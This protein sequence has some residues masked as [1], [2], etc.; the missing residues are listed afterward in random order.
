MKNAVLIFI[1]TLAVYTVNAQ[2]YYGEG[3]FKFQVGANLQSDGSGIVATLDKGV[4]E[5]ISLGV[6]GAYLLGVEEAFDADFSERFDLKA[7][8]NAHLGSVLEL[9]DEMD[10]YPGLDLGLK[11]F[12][13]HLGVRYFFSDGF[14]LFFEANTPI[15]KYKTDLTPAEE[16]FN[17]FNVSVG[18][19]FNL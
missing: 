3:D 15:A 16:Y 17:Q 2:A 14:G 9:G 18:A 7:R 13:A 10:I 1:L 19:S 5:N 12:G 8:F 11:N 4:G 6:A